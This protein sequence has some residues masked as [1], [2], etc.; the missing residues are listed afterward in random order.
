MYWHYG[1]CHKYEGTEADVYGRFHS[2]TQPAII[3]SNKQV[4]KTRNHNEEYV[5]E[6]KGYAVLQGQLN[7]PGGTWAVHHHGGIH[8]SQYNNIIDAAIKFGSSGQQPGALVE[9][10]RVIRKRGSDT[11]WYQRCLGALV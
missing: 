10:G 11:H 4:L 6:L 3:C 1:G 8:K 2:E 9:D 7:L 5:E